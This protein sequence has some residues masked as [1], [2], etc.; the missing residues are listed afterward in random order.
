MAYHVH[1]NLFTSNLISRN[2]TIQLYN[3]LIR[4]TVTYGSETWVLKENM[5]KKLMIFERRIM[6]KI[7]VPARTNDGYCRIKTNQEIN[8]ILK[9]QNIIGFIKK[10]RLNWLGHVERMAEDNN[11]LKTKRWK[12]MSKRPIGRPKTRWEEDVLE[13]I[14]SMNV[15]NWKKVV[16]NRDSWKK[17]VEQ[18]RTLHRL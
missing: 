14:K 9:G 5:I 8:E 4:P 6:R 2:V 13:D 18:A 7:F 12:P 15:C 16:Q 17:V 10:Q 11:V 3:P 1:R